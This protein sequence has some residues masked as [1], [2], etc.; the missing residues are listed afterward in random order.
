[1]VL[2]LVGSWCWWGVGVGVVA[3]DE[4]LLVLLGV[5][6]WWCCWGV[7]VG[8]VGGDGVLVMLLWMGCW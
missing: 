5:G 3:G 4:V 1:M 7:C 6:C 8:G 2:V